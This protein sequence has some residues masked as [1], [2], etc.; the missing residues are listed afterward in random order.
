MTS[1]ALAHAIIIAGYAVAVVAMLRQRWAVAIAAMLAAAVLWMITTTEML[2][3]PRPSDKPPEG[4]VV[5]SVLP[6]PNEAIFLYGLMETGGEPLSLRLPWDDADAQRLVEQM[7]E[8]SERGGRVKF[9]T[10][11]VPG[12]AG[13]FDIEL[14]PESPP[15]QPVS[16]RLVPG[17]VHVSAPVYRIVEG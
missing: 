4:Y 10:P 17:A 2:G 9:R 13:R 6:I 5:A 3:L 8:A 11:S 7:E 14:P 16:S 12:S 1:I 15:K